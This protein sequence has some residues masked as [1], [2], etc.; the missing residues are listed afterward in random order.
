MASR[1]LQK[2]T[3]W[4][5]DYCKQEG[6]KHKNMTIYVKSAYQPKLVL[7]QTIDI[8]G[9]QELD[10]SDWEQRNDIKMIYSCDGTWEVKAKHR[11][12]TLNKYEIKGMMVHPSNC[13]LI[14]DNWPLVKRS[15]FRDNMT[16]KAILMKKRRWFPNMTNEENFKFY[17]THSESNNTYGT[18]EVALFS[19]PIMVSLLA[20]FDPMTFYLT[21]S[22]ALAPILVTALRWMTYMGFLNEIARPRGVIKLL[23]AVHLHRH[24][25][26]L[27]AE[28]E[29]YYL[30]VEI[31]R[32]PELLR[33]MSGSRI[34]GSA[35]PELDGLSEKQK[36]KLEH[37]DYLQMRGFEVDILKEKILSGQAEIFDEDE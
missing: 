31:I 20:E 12:T 14:R 3:Y 9:I 29:T 16:K 2:W 17:R 8:W 36:K 37:L 10:K 15:H 11:P 7:G 34:R 32:S 33:A 21:V 1:D 19:L 5:T 28:E 30:V 35:S 4:E 22:L 6:N 26:N 25:E 18:M 13:S 24:E 23:E 27:P